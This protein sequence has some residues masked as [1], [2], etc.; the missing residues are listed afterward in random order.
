MGSNQ[1]GSGRFSEAAAFNCHSPGQFV[2][3]PADPQLFSPTTR[4]TRRASSASARI[5]TPSRT[6]LCLAAW[7]RVLPLPTRTGRQSWPELQSRVYLKAASRV[8]RKGRLLIGLFPILLW[9]V[10]AAAR[11]FRLWVRAD[12]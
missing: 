6:V 2:N 1:T 10:S 12:T 3:E 5:G 7:T 9:C 11:L 4:L 8:K